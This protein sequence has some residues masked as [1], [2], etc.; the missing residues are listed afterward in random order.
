MK[1]AKNKLNTLVT[2]GILSADEQHKVE[3]SLLEH[4]YSQ[5]IVALSSSFFCAAVIFIGFYNSE[6]SNHRLFVWFG[7]FLVITVLRLSI[8]FQCKK[9]VAVTNMK[10]Q[11]NIYAV[12]C[13]L[14]G[15]SWGLASILLLP[16]ANSTQQLLLILMLAGVSSGAVPVSAAVPK[17]GIAFLVASILPFIIS[18][19]DFRNYSYY[20]FDMALTLYL[21]YTIILTFKIY[22]LIKNAVILKHENDVLLIDLTIS[23]K[24]LENAATHDPLT[25]IS[26]RRLFQEKFSEALNRGKTKNLMVALFY[27]DLDNFKLINDTY[28]HNGGDIVLK[29]VSD[30]VSA[31][32]RKTDMLARLGGD[33]FAIIIEDAIDKN[34][35]KNIA[36]KICQ[37]IAMPTRMNNISLS[38]TASV[39]ISVYPDDG[40][41]VEELV[42]CADHRMFYAKKQGGN[43]F[44]FKS[45]D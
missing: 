23:N 4:V 19:L 10:L 44:S 20:L 16:Y 35:L 14:G 43:N 37:L 3:L 15:A 18:I 36:V 30:K 9:K 1:S 39:G 13:F 32:F 29:N 12:S 26:N 11:H 7:T 34:E 38:V 2:D 41:N 22:K 33:E 17:A 24:M 5:V 6:I 42:T 31:F 25:E 21:I 45:D 8:Y 40:N 27:F 28:G